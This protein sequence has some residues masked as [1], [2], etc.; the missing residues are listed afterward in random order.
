MLG[1]L[2]AVN[3]A[4]T[5]VSD[6]CESAQIYL[7]KV[8]TAYVTSWY[9]YRKTGQVSSSISFVKESPYLVIYHFVM[10]IFFDTV[11]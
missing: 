11:F 9:S 5:R 10:K 1:Y 7:Y 8:V 6:R 3:V 2:G 4:N